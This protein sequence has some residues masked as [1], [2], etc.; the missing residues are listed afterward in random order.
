MYQCLRREHSVDDLDID[1][2]RRALVSGSHSELDRIF[3]RRDSVGILNCHE[4]AAELSVRDRE[5]VARLIRDQQIGVEPGRSAQVI[6]VMRLR[7]SGERDRHKL[8][9]RDFDILGERAFNRQRRVKLRRLGD[10]VAGIRELERQALVCEHGHIRKRRLLFDGL[11]EEALLD[12]GQNFSNNRHDFDFLSGER[13]ILRVVS[14]SRC[15]SER[16]ES[17]WSQSAY[18]GLRALVENRRRRFSLKI[19]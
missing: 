1:A 4:H 5:H 3:A 9:L 15:E 10:I 13:F 6:V 17:V 18:G 14:D 8:N 7:I 19:T 2:R 16:V 12:R 11:I